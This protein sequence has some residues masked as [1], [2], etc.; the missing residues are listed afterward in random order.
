[1]A[2]STPPTDPDSLAIL[3]GLSDKDLSP[4]D[5]YNAL[6]ALRNL[7]GKSIIAM[8]EVQ[9]AKIDA[10]NA[11]ID[12]KIDAINAKLDAKIDALQGHLR[13]ERAMLWTVIAL[14]G[15]AVLRYLVMG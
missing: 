1:M 3:H 13:R 14:L 12:A 8:I 2:T 11:K 5:A 4:Q 9:N 10:I 6:E 15:A 7:A